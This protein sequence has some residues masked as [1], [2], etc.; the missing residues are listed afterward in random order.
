[1][2]HARHYHE[3]GANRQAQA[4]LAMFQYFLGDGIEGSWNNDY[5]KYDADIQISRWENGREHGYVL[6][7][8]SKDWKRQFNVAF[9]EHRSCDNIDVAC[10]EQT[11]YNPP[12]FDTKAGKGEQDYNWAWENNTKSFGYG[13]VAEAARY[14]LEE[15]ESFWHESLIE[16]A[17]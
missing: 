9:Y 6:H 4:T 16:D 8:R 1:M 13:K 5:H 12:A 14:I 2:T 17:A 15:L 7:M 10:W 3:D 11:T